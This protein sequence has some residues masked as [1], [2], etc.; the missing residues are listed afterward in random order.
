MLNINIQ[1]PRDPDIIKLASGP[2]ESF[3]SRYQHKSAAKA[4]IPRFVTYVF[5]RSLRFP[6]TIKTI[7]NPEDVIRSDNKHNKRISVQTVHYLCLS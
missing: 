3:A 7:G 4:T 1:I 5:I 2:A 6:L